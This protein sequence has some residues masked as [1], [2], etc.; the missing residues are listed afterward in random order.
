[1]EVLIIVLLLAW[2]VPIG[3]VGAVVKSRNRSMHYLWWPAILGRLGA[4]VVLVIVLVQ[5]EKEVASQEP[6]L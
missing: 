4:I 3:V 2:L 1:M 6:R 5:K